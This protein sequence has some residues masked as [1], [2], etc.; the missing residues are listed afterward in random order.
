MFY[1]VTTKEVQHVSK[2]ILFYE[3]Q[4]INLYSFDGEK[5]KNYEVMASFEFRN[6]NIDFKMSVVEWQHGCCLHYGSLF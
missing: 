6:K 3:N 5:S 1:W 4:K 2:P